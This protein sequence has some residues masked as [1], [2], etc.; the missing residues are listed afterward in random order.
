MTGLR[1]RKKREVRHRIVQVAASLFLDKGF[2]DTTMEEIAAAADVSVGT[3]YNYFGT[4]TAVLVAGVEED[5]IEMVELG[6]AILTKPGANPRRAVKQLFAIYFDHLAAW[7]R[8][9]LREVISASFQPGAADMTAELVQLDTH[10]LDQ[11]SALLLHFVAEGRLRSGTSTE[12][13]SLLLYSILATHLLM[14]ISLEAFPIG[15]LK[16]Q[17]DRQIDLAFSGL[18]DTSK[19]EK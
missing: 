2:D 17:I 9:L 13:A 16:R 10:L 19:K 18:S 3:V 5:T 12:E 7:D 15:D 1:E 8:D 11:T 4:K 14:Y 6:K